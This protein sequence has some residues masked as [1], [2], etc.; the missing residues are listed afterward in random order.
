MNEVPEWKPT[1]RL[2]RSAEKAPFLA[3]SADLVKSLEEARQ[4]YLKKRFREAASILESALSRFGPSVVLNSRLADVYVEIGDP[5]RARA[6]ELE[7]VRLDPNSYRGHYNLGCD[8]RDLGRVAETRDCFQTAIRLNPGY[9]KAYCNLAELTN[10]PKQALALLR[11]AASIDPDDEDYKRGI[12]MWEPLAEAERID[13]APQRVLWAQQALEKKEFRYARLH[14]R[15]AQ[16]AAASPI[17]EGMVYSCE[18]DLR[19][20][21]GDLRGSIVSLEQAV[22]RDPSRAFYWNNL[23]ARRLLVARE[24]ETPR[25]EAW[26]LLQRSKVESLK[27]VECADYARPHQN[28]AFAHLSLGE[29][30]DARRDAQVAYDMACRQIAAGPLGGRICVGC[31]TEAKMPEECRGC[32]EKAKSTLRDIELASG[33]YRV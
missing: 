20:Q 31:P 22:L 9:A 3:A 23:A 17:E 4:A 25:D 24:P 26:Q 1:E 30:D 21:E 27:A 12:S 18:S 14:I 33:R 10:D 2:A 13:W 11:K 32:R 28:L 6:Y 15:L 16:E 19:R 7:A 8:Y 29:L 5:E